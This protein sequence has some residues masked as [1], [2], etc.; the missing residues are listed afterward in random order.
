MP[1]PRWAT[2]GAPFVIVNIVGFA[3]AL[4]VSMIGLNDA[5]A[6]TGSPETLNEME[7]VNPF[8]VGVAVI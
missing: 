4:S 6:P 7:F 1:E 5:E 3:T 2:A 8:A